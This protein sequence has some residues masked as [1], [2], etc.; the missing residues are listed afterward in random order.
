MLIEFKH[1]TLRTALELGMDL[2][3]AQ[4]DHI[5]QL[6]GLDEQ[7]KSALHNTELIQKQ[8]KQWHDKF[9]KDQVFLVGNWALLYDSRYQHHQGKFQTHWLGPYEIISIFD[10]SAV[11]LSTVDPIRFK[12]LVNGHQ[13]KLY[14]KL[15]SQDLFLQQ[16]SSHEVLLPTT[17]S[18]ESSTQTPTAS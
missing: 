3:A 5:L 17:S 14:H 18:S 9:I 1:K 11:Q 16:F 8:H 15:A 12:L 10:N 2:P 6:N 13:L 4:Q 7:E